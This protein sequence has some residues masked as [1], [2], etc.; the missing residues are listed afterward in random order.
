M[1]RVPGLTN[2]DAK[3]VRTSY[4]GDGT[5]GM[6]LSRKSI[7]IWILQEM[8]EEKWIG[9]APALSNAGWF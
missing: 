5:D 7:A 8:E 3:P 4:L 1:G 6:M 9:K 2:G